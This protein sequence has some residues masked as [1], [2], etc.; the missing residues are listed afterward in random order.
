MSSLDDGHETNAGRAYKLL[1]EASPS[2]SLYYE[3][4]LQ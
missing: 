1:S 3:A 4:G 2:L